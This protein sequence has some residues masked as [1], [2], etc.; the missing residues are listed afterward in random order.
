MKRIVLLTVF[1]VLFILS[2]CGPAP[3]ANGAAPTGDHLVQFDDQGVAVLSGFMT[4][5]SIDPGEDEILYFNVLATIDG[6][7]ANVRVPIRVQRDTI[8]ASTTTTERDV[9]EYMTFN[10]G[11]Y[12]YDAF[13]PGAFEE[14]SFR[15]SGDSFVAVTIREVKKGFWYPY[16]EKKANLDTL[17]VKDGF[18]RGT[19]IGHIGEPSRNDDGS[20]TWKLSI[21]IMVQGVQA[22]VWVWVETE[23]DVQLDTTSGAAITI[24]SLHGDVQVE[25][26][27]SGK[28]LKATHITALR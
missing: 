19:L 11:K 21:P 27:R 12:A 8:I 24:E 25:F 5:A 23:P 26:K 14:V 4:G 17:I 9:L 20:A 22:D 7:I 10:P 13:P 1:L 2:A 16:F 15:K 28:T 6:A 3:A 18:S